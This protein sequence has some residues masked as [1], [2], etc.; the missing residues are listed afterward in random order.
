MKCRCRAWGGREWTRDCA[1]EKR[2]KSAFHFWTTSK[3]V[4]PA[5]G[6]KRKRRARW[7]WD[8][9]R[10]EAQRKQQF[11]TRFLPT[12]PGRTA[13]SEIIDPS[14]SCE[15]PWSFQ[16]LFWTAVLDHILTSRGKC[17]EV[18]LSLLILLSMPPPPPKKNKKVILITSVI[19][20]N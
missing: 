20:D 9:Y 16:M 13:T 2:L 7:R 10:P 12:K 4:Q 8:C 19:T 15:S 18:S 1:R 3:T 14:K 11:Y 17:S 6:L 5:I